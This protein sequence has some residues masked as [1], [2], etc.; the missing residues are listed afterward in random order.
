MTIFRI[1]KLLFFLKIT[2]SFYP[3]NLDS[4]KRDQNSVVHTTIAIQNLLLL[5]GAGLEHWK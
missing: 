4:E 1:Y 2:P 3:I 5:E